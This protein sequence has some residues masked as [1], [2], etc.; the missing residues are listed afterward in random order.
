[1]RSAP[2]G[3]WLSSPGGPSR[4]TGV[5]AHFYPEVGDRL[6]MRAHT[7]LDPSEP[8]GADLLTP[9]FQ[10][11][12]GGERGGARTHGLRRKGPGLAMFRC[13]PQCREVFSHKESHRIG[14]SRFFSIVPLFWPVC[15]HSLTRKRPD[16]PVI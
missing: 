3:R 7:G 8:K 13:C 1:V 4:D 2:G 10:E 12:H 5:M 6:A 16:T 15:E 14:L 9:P 11:T